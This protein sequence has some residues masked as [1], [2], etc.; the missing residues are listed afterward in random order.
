MEQL[1]N[2]KAILNLIKT[3]EGVDF[4]YNE[5]GIFEEYNF[6]I[7]NTSSLAIKI[8]SI[9]GGFLASLAF[10]GFLFLTGLYDSPIGLIIFGFVFITTAIVLNKAYKQL[11]IDTFSVAIYSIGYIMLCVGLLEHD[12]DLNW[13]NLLIIIIAFIAL[14]VTQNYILSF[15]SI[16]TVNANIFILIVENRYDILPIYVALNTALL[17]YIFLNEAKII[18][19]NNILSR[20]YNP[21]KIGTVIALIIGLYLIDDNFKT[22]TFHYLTWIANTIIII[23]TLYLVNAII[24]INNIVNL[25]S[26]ILI[27]FLSTIILITT[28]FSSAIVGALVIILSS[29]Y[30]N[31]KTGFAIGIIAMIYFISQY[32]YFMDQTLLTKSI[33]LITLGIVFLLIYFITT[34]PLNEKA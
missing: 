34:I 32:Y 17:V 15:I 8:I 4:E 22:L 16:L 12:V 6:N 28:F 11:I 1:N 21:L 26:K 5:K 7:E 24:K 18:K 10:C 27:F 30:I 3:N 23:T 2:K 20:L 13:V 29:F 14:I 31:Y 33:I 19:I 9:L 25:K